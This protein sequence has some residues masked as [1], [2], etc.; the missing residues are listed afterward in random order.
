MYTITMSS[1]LKK[2][3]LLK[4]QQI[5]LV[6]K[7]LLNYMDTMGDESGELEKLLNSLYIKRDNAEISKKHLESLG[8]KV[9]PPVEKE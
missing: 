2:S 9:I 5:V 8:Y 1:K 4:A 6:E 3:K 7:S